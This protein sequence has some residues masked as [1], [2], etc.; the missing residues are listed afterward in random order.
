MI[1]LIELI[2]IL[3]SFCVVMMTS[4][5][6]STPL[7]MPNIKAYAD[8]MLVW[9]QDD[10]KKG[11][12]HHWRIYANKKGIKLWK[13]D[14]LSLLSDTKVEFLDSFY[15]FK[16]RKKLIGIGSDPKSDK[17]SY[18]A[19]IEDFIILNK[20]VQDEKTRI[21]HKV[22][23]VNKLKNAIT[24]KN[25]SNVL[26]PQYAPDKNAPYIDYEF[27]NLDFGY[28]YDFYPPNSK[29]SSKN[30]Y[31]LLGT[32]PNFS[33]VAKSNAPNSAKS[34]IKGWV[35]KNHIIRWKT[36][37]GLEP[38]TQRTHPI[39]F[40]KDQDE[41][42]NF[43][44]S[45][46][47]DN[48]IRP[49]DKIIAAKADWTKIDRK[50][51][52][53][54]E[55]RYLIKEECEN[56]SV[57]LTITGSKYNY[58]VVEKVSTI[59]NNTKNVDLIFVIDA[60]L[61]MT[62]YIKTVAKLAN[63]LVY[64]LNRILLNETNR[65]GWL[66]SFRVGAS[67]YR[68]Y[69]DKDDVYD[70]ISLTEDINSVIHWLNSI[71]CYSSVT[72]KDRPIDAF[73]REAVFQGLHKT[74]KS[75]QWG[76][77]NTHIIIHIGDTGNHSRSRDNFTSDKI[78]ELLVSE[79]NTIISYI[80]IHVRHKSYSNDLELNSVN[81]F[82]S[83]TKNICRS[84]FSNWEKNQSSICDSIKNKK[85]C[86]DNLQEAKES[87]S[88]NEGLWY[89]RDVI[90]PKGAAAEINTIIDEV[91]DQISYQLNV[92]EKFLI[93]GHLPEKWTYNGGNTWEPAINA[94]IQKQLFDSLRG[95]VYEKNN[96]GNMRFSQK[97]FAKMKIDDSNTNQFVKS[98]LFSKDDLAYNLMPA[99]R[100]MAQYGWTINDPITLWNVYKKMI[101]SLTGETDETLDFDFE[102]SLDDYYKM[103]LGINFVNEHSLLKIKLEDV[104]RGKIGDFDTV[105]VL[106]NKLE[107]IYEKLK[108]ILNEDKRWF[109]TLSG[110]Q[111]CWVKSNELP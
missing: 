39:F 88:K 10:Y 13:D 74:I 43:Y 31:I 21:S 12:I 76:S 85:A 71:H 8:R 57:I 60:T 54:H 59:R 53:A 87:Y 78:G 89:V 49:D 73:Y 77:N 37:E 90:E 29:Y 61:S 65:E 16:K 46:I 109:T 82:N 63:N 93:E 47:K 111:Y 26:K 108:K 106:I 17:I 11:Q 33:I 38:N 64:K 18:W 95:Q 51:W 20:P 42:E 35:H 50:E 102:K 41:M 103:A 36:R 3:L 5:A 56:N 70:S 96:Q 80:A 52:P 68:D 84:A 91:I 92:Y 44:K 7:P 79:L 101:L 6:F 94:E 105:Q 98:V 19:N 104:R 58:N 9:K 99:L 55:P 69:L 15:V 100:V 40:F 23:F 1:R 66:K 27:N 4:N 97:V 34:V 32:R 62:P 48:S 22:I 86:F 83:N 75:S 107:N 30:E 67:I 25:Y 72:N 2:F 24:Y 110:D 81:D 14:N 28:I 45:Y